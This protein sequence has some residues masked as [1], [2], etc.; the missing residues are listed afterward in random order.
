MKIKTVL[1]II[2]VSVFLISAGI[3]LANLE[4]YAAQA[5]PVYINKDNSGANPVTDK[6]ATLGRVLFYDKKLSVNNTISCASCHQQ[7]FAFGDTARLSK[8]FAGGLTDRH[9]MRL[10]N[11]RFSQETK[12]FWDERATTLEFQTTQPI[13]NEIEM[14]YNGQTANTAFNAL[15]LKLSQTSYYGSLFSFVYGDPAI[16]EARIQNALAQFIR[17]IQSFDSKFDVGLS[18]APN[19]N[20]PFANFSTIENEGKTLFLSPPAQG[21]A[22]CQGCHRAPEFDIDPNS[23][24][25]GIVAAASGNTIDLTNTR[26]PSLRDLFNNNGT[27]N[28]PLMHNGNLNTIDLV[29]NHYNQVPVTPGNTNLDPKLTG[30]GGNLNLSQSQKNALKAFLK[31]LS[32]NKLYTD[33]KW[34]D[35]FDQNGNLIGSTLGIATYQAPEFSLYPNPAKDQLNILIKDGDYTLRFMDISGREIALYN[36]SGSQ[37]LDIS[38][39]ERGLLLVEISDRNSGLSTVKK[40]VRY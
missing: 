17:S 14:G 40:I 20:A 30:P 24:N 26:A 27:L 21:G 34:S 11:A 31:T 19:L 32:G 8:G 2:P 39:F 4:N 12:F 35:P 37:L 7:A 25:N 15:L 28:G 5:K 18:Q 23:K 3:D 38:N 10:V 22:G 1:F 29:I 33:A 16:T 13:R 36:V 6:G 9:A